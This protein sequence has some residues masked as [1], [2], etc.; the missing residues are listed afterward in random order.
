[1]LYKAGD[2]FT[3]FS[4]RYV[5]SAI[6]FCSSNSSSFTFTFRFLA[7]NGR[8]FDFLNYSPSVKNPTGDWDSLRFFF[9]LLCFLV[10]IGIA[11][12]TNFGRPSLLCDVAS[13][14][15]RGETE[16]YSEFIFGI[17]SL[18]F[19]Y[20]KVKDFFSIFPRNGL[21]LRVWFPASTR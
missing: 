2:F 18:V 11:W 17:I 12:S 10:M 14:R 13:L 15:L 20:W 6:Y 21:L 7:Y 3:S 9:S 19:L 16:I 1:M 4:N 5:Y 8:L